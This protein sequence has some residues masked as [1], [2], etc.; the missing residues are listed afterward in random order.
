MKGKKEI[1]EIHWEDYVVQVSRWAFTLFERS[2][3][4]S[5]KNKGEEY[6]NFITDHTNLE[7]A[8]KSMLHQE[9]LKH[10]DTFSLKEYIQLWK[11]ISLQMK[12]DLH[13]ELSVVSY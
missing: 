13:K 4:K 8:L 1:V 12:A 6:L 2:I 11:D 7:N 5:G 10:G 9:S 3:R